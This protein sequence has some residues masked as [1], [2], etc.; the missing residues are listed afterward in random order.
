MWLGAPRA[1]TAWVAESSARVDCWFK[2]QAAEGR[3]SDAC[4]HQEWWGAASLSTP[5]GAM[6]SKTQPRAEVDVSLDVDLSGAGSSKVK[7]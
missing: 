6:D 1:V 5:Q 4:L 2:Q 3:A 7:S